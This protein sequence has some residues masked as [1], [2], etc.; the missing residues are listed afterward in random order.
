MGQPVINR[1]DIPISSDENSPVIK[2]DLL[3]PGYGITVRY[4][5]VNFGN[6]HAVIFID[7]VPDFIKI[8]DIPLSDWGPIIEN[9]T[10]KFPNRINVEFVEVINPGH[11]KMRVWERGAGITLSCGSGVAA[12][13]AACHLTGYAGDNLRVDVPGGS[14]VTEFSGSGV[15][16]LSGPAVKAF[17]GE[18]VS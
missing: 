9:Y 17:V 5:G 10:G 4:T 15:V 14:L 8:D 2:E 1:R 7:D 13:Q 6:P 18:W 11:V 12:V 16:F 3:I